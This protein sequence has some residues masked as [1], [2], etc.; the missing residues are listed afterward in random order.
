MKRS[1]RSVSLWWREMVLHPRKEMRFAHLSS[2]TA[3][4][5]IK[6]WLQTLNLFEL[7]QTK[8]ILASMLPLILLMMLVFFP[9]HPW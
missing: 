1:V 8:D 5:A 7:S 6:K 9:H 2:A 3:A 4:D